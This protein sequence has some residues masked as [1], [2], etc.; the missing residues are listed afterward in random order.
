GCEGQSTCDPLGTR[1]CVSSVST[2]SSV[3]DLPFTCL[4]HP[5]YMGTRCEKKRDACIE[6]ENPDQM[7]G[8]QA[9]RVF[10]G[11]T[12]EP[13]IGTNF[14]TCHCNGLFI[15]DKFIAFPNCFQ[16]RPICSAVICNR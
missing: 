3:K 6:N 4:C 12:C 13:R 10:L 15:A 9:C 11:N 5:G 7:S 8:N 1:I 2:I 14:Y 16:R